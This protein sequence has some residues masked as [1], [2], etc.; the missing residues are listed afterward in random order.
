[1]TSKPQ[2]LVLLSLLASCDGHPPE[3]FPAP[4]SGSYDVYCSPPFPV[5]DPE[6]DVDTFELEWTGE[7]VF[8]RYATLEGVNVVVEYEVR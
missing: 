1:M 6:I 7:R 3:L 5:I 4:A 2:Y 8:V